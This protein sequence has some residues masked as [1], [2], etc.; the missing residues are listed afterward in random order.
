MEPKPNLNRLLI[1]SF[2]KKVVRL[3]T[4][5]WDEHGYP[6]PMGSKGK[7]TFFQQKRIQNSQKSQSL[8]EISQ[9]FSSTVFPYIVSVET[10]LFL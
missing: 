2:E 4:T 10:I 3:G 1:W 8:F 5:L 9:I 7:A 6:I